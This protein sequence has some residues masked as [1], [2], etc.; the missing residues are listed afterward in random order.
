MSDSLIQYGRKANSKEIENILN[1]I[2]DSNLNIEEIDKKP[3]PLCIWG[4]HG[5][6]KT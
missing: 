6:G 3:T 4:T 2:F 1:Y 5:L